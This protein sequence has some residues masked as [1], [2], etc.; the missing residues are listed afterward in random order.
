MG[1]DTSRMTYDYPTSNAITSVAPVPTLGSRVTRHSS[2]NVPPIAAIGGG[3]GFYMDS[4]SGR[5]SPRVTLNHS[6]SMGGFQSMQQP[7]S[8]RSS[9]AGSSTGGMSL[10]RM[11]RKGLLA[12]FGSAQERES[13]ALQRFREVSHLFEIHF[14]FR[15]ETF[16]SEE[17]LTIL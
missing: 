17:F 13:A 10:T 9:V 2:F 3:S 6:T 5:E 14:L 7:G 8:G 16:V 11:M 15:V 12:E 4:S 1:S